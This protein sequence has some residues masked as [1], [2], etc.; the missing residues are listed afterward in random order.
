MANFN[1]RER[2]IMTV[3]G[4]SN[5]TSESNSKAAYY[6]WVGG[7]LFTVMFTLLIW[8][9]GPYLDPVLTTLLPDQ[10]AAW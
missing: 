5:Q 2:E 4:D 1:F 9:L 3:K 10:G 8:M 7:L 6:V